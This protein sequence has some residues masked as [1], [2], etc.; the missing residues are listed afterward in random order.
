[1]K[2]IASRFRSALSPD[3]EDH[4][5]ARR[6]IE[7][8]VQHVDLFGS[9]LEPI[10][11]PISIEQ[12]RRRSEF[13]HA[14]VRNEAVDM[15]KLSG[16][17]VETDSR[18][19]GTFES[20]FVRTKEGKLTIRESETDE[21]AAETVVSITQQ[22]ERKSSTESAPLYQSP[23]SQQSLNSTPSPTQPIPIASPPAGSP[24]T[25]HERRPSVQPPSWSGEALV[26]VLSQFSFPSSSPA[27][28]S[29][30]GDDEPR[31]YSFN[32]ADHF[33]STSSTT[34]AS[35]GNSV[36]GGYY[37]NGQDESEIEEELGLG[38][39]VPGVYQA[40]Y[41]FIPELETE[42]KLSVGEWVSVFERQCAGWVR[43]RFIYI[44]RAFRLLIFAGLDSC[45]FKQEELSMEF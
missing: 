17:V 40:V 2:R 21:S 13:E 44:T 23:S 18:E 32:D 38:E 20:S 27:S 14:R 24:Q 37:S 28:S 4:I 10:P 6:T 22:E 5:S 1:M 34:G 16:R 39:F 31:G 33:G 15:D 26:P 42:M 29:F 30:D 8:P 19:T 43:F 36:G 9:S 25:R 41:E 3:I 35:G 11:A 7:A 45:R 12:E